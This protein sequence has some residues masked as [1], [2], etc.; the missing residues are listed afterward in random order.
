MF[1]GGL[2]HGAGFGFIVWGLYHGLLL[3][4]YRLLPID[5]VLRERLG[6]RDRSSRSS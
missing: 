3:I 6:R 5:R 4:L 2:W 1:L